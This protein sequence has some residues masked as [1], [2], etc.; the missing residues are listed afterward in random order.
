MFNPRG[1][2]P[3]KRVPLTGFS[4]P[5]ILLWPWKPRAMAAGMIVIQDLFGMGTSDR[6]V[7]LTRLQFTHLLHGRLTDLIEPLGSG[8]SF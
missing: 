7:F 6:S 3:G 4:C 1:W 2:G 5:S 8:S